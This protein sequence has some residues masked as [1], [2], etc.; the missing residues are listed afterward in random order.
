MPGTKSRAVLLA[1][2]LLFT[3]VPAAAD[4][5][6]VRWPAEGE[7]LA[8]AEVL[9]AGLLELAGK[10]TRGLMLRSQNRSSAG[11]RTSG[12]GLYQLIG[13]KGA[14]VASVVIRGFRLEEN[15]KAN[16][17]LIQVWH[18]DGDLL[19]F[20]DQPELTGGPAGLLLNIPAASAIGGRVQA[21]AI[22]LHAPAE[23]AAELAVDGLD[24]R[25]DAPGDPDAS[26][27]W[28][29]EAARIV[30]AGE[31]EFFATMS[32]AGFSAPAGIG[33]DAAKVTIRIGEGRFSADIGKTRI[34]RALSSAI[35][36]ELQLARDDL[37]G[38]LELAW[39][40]GMQRGQAESIAIS[41]HILA[42]GT[43][44]AVIKGSLDAAG[45]A[46]SLS[47]RVDGLL[48][49]LA[50]RGAAGPAALAAK[51]LGLLYRAEDAA[52]DSVALGIEANPL[53]L[54]ING[55]PVVLEGGR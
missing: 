1:A 52:Q 7:T 37:N 38:R 18:P 2:G 35:F 32:G 48:T 53:W 39:A 40:E 49:M 20:L 23:G 27:R 21:G 8:L 31:G 50:E 42:A 16:A 26:L 43:L 14:T 29:V 34:S 24:G 19:L 22:R 17:R 51:R 36:P 5:E 11:D 47:G 10:S 6:L 28:K 4:G 44:Q 3:G 46:L 55:R 33:A 12:G 15:R 41:G 9:P 30:A 45:Q 13:R 54:R 25:I